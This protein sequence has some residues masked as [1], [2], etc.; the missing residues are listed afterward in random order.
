MK[1]TIYNHGLTQR[2]LEIISGF[3][4]H[5]IPS[6][7]LSKMEMA[8]NFSGFQYRRKGTKFDLQPLTLRRLPLHYPQHWPQGENR[9]L[10]SPHSA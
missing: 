5:V 7:L 4:N 1:L 3:D 8:R 6:A 9:F 10:L 2:L